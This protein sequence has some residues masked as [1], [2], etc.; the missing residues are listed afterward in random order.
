MR[1]NRMITAGAL[2]LALAAAAA[3]NA[4]ANLANTQQARQSAREALQGE[5]AVSWEE[6]L[7]PVFEQE[8]KEQ[9]DEALRMGLTLMK[10]N[11]EGMNRKQMLEEITRAVVEAGRPAG[12]MPETFITFS[13]SN[14]TMD[15]IAP[16]G[17]RKTTASG[18]FTADG[19]TIRTDNGSSP[20]TL[21][22]NTLTMEVK[23]QKLVCHKVE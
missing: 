1:T 9:S 16:D 4:C 2:A 20:Y 7:Q 3:L 6:T 23:G 11:P 19:T 17:T 21:Q 14:M 8:F 5:W 10:V 18:S 15:T 22:D 12:N 13:G